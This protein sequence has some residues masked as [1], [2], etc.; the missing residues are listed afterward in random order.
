MDPILIAYVAK[1]GI[2]TVTTLIDAWKKSGEPTAE[3]IRAAFIEKKPED[4]FK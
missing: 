1:L 3:E 4:Y 2:D